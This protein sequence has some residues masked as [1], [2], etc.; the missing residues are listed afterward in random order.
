MLHKPCLLPLYSVHVERKQMPLFNLLLFEIFY[1]I[2]LHAILNG[3]PMNNNIFMQRRD[4]CYTS[5]PKASLAIMTKRTCTYLQKSQKRKSTIKGINIVGHFIFDK[6]GVNQYNASSVGKE[7]ACN[8]GDPSLTP[9]LG[10]STGE[11]TG[12]LLQY[13]WA[14]L[15]AQ[16][17]ECTCRAGDLGLIPGLGKSPGEGKGYPL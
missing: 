4:I 15:V 13:S 14:S 7:S 3:T 16:L 9:G 10:R 12:Y 6:H 11:G 8:A 5:T 1:C 2:Q 17:K